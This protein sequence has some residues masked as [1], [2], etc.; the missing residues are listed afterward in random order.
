M[1]NTESDLSLRLR[2]E[3]LYAEYAHTIDDD[4]LEEWPGLFTDNAIYRVTTRENY[5]NGLPLAMVYCDGRGMMADRISALRTANI[6]EPHVY[7]HMLSAVRVLSQD[8][9]GSGGVIRARSN[10]SVLRTMQEGETMLFAVGRT[11]DKIVED[12]GRLRF[13]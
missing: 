13:A 4:R 10:F 9:G 7:C 5:D 2:V 12:G 3:D 8:S 6:F 11:F 1:T